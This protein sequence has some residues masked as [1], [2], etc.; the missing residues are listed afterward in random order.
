MRSKFLVRTPVDR[1]FKPHTDIPML[2]THR[3]VSSPRVKIVFENLYG[4]V[5]NRTGR[6]MSAAPL[7]LARNP[8]WVA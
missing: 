2:L 1:F 6:Y 4:I 7:E 8:Y 5:F 3:L